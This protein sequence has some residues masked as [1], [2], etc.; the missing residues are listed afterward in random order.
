M[1]SVLRQ[2]FSQRV[3]TEIF[4]ER[5]R[6][7]E[8]EEKGKK[9]SAMSTLA[10][11]SNGDFSAEHKAPNCKRLKKLV[12]DECVA[13][14]RCINKGTN[15]SSWDV[16]RLRQENTKKILKEKK[17]MLILDLDNTLLHSV[18]DGDLSSEDERLMQ[19]RES[20]E[21][22][23]GR[24]VFRWRGMATKL[25]PHVRSFL[26]EAKGVYFENKILSS[27]DCTR[28]RR[29]G[30]DVVLGEEKAM[31]IVDDN[32]K[33]WGKHVMNQ[34]D[35]KRYHFFG[36]KR[37]LFD[38][39]GNAL[40]EM[41]ELES[42]ESELA[43]CLELLRCIHWLFFNPVNHADFYD[44]DVRQI[45]MDIKDEVEYGSGVGLKVQCPC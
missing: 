25:R 39:D 10:L 20:S 24:S 34:I 21:D 8:R 31:V 42:K 23:R 29:K 43:R 4:T 37:P 15:V 5:D 28:P 18:R 36:P 27:E 45:L 7:R 19:M 3:E 9:K 38:L 13:S 12:G 40:S 17:L 35:I 14:L 30:L 32:D 16:A 2:R 44:S 6:E 33:V 26:K 11:S 41:E 1:T 22:E